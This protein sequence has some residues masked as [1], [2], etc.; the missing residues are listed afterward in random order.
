MLYKNIILAFRLL[1]RDKIYSLVTFVGLATG[2]AASLLIYL[3][4]LDEMSYDSFHEKGENIYKIITRH[5]ID[6]DEIWT[7][8]PF[9]LA[10]GLA[11]HFPEIIDFTRTFTV[12]E[13]I[14]YEGKTVRPDAIMLID[15]GFLEIF[16][17]ELIRGNAANVFSSLNDII[18]TETLSYQLFGETDPLGKMVSA[19]DKHLRI[20]G[21]VEDPPANT[22]LQFDVLGQIDILEEQRLQSWT[23]AE[24]SYILL[25]EGTNPRKFEQQIRDIYHQLDPGSNYYPQLQNI[26]EVYLFQHA[27]PG[28]ILYVYLFSLIS[29]VII[30]I[31]CINFMNLSV[32]RYSARNKEIAIRKANGASR[33]QIMRQVFTETI[34][35][36]I[37]STIMGLIMLELFRPE[38]NLLTGKQVIIDYTNAGFVLGIVILMVL[39]IIISGSYPAFISS[40]FSPVSIFQRRGRNQI[41]GRGFLSLLVVFQF[42]VSLTLIICAIYF[43][44]QLSYIRNKN[45]GYDKDQIIVLWCNS[46]LRNGYDVYKDQLLKIPGIEFVSATT[47]LPNNVHWQVELDWEGNP[48]TEEIPVRYLMVDYDFIE[49][50]KMK[51]VQ[52]RSFSPDYV[53]DDSISYIINETAARMI[54]EDNLIGKRVEFIHPDFPERF[55]KGSIIGIVGDFHFRPLK[56]RS[57]AFVMRMYRPWYGYL[58]IR[59]GSSDLPATLEQIE[60]TTRK[61]FPD[62]PYEHRFFDETFDNL[63]RSEIVSGQ[64]IK[65]FAILSIIISM[66]GLFGQTSYNAEKRTKEIAIRK[67]NGGGYYAIL[68]MLFLD[69]TKRIMI[70]IALAIPASL[71]ILNWV[72]RNYAHHSPLSLWIFVLSGLIALFIA[73]ITVAYHL[74]IITKRNPVD[75]LRYE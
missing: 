3:W 63:Y 22:I 31:A 1:V 62:Y 25:Q 32:A 8:S 6:P 23:F 33:L 58:L 28:R 47:L 65:Y 12:T 51:M 35:M 18:I 21:V 41:M 50:M 2:I 69:F 42:F 27:K 61:Q 72:L 45:L 30:L 56:E 57:G 14:I 55:R 4:V 64:L 44:K 19:E 60:K 75:G 38:F 16:S 26:R 48:D 71:L 70:A 11:E 37:F 9:P 20:S 29:L 59:T 67:V 10:P 13:S 24:N 73:G 40:S 49:T 68:G 54:G 36:I 34:L 7:S 53:S 74:L 52:G 39:T 66:L 5:K 15:P 43:T 46:D 17:F